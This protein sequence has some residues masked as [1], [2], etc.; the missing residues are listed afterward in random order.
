M[1]GRLFLDFDLFCVGG[2]CLGGGGPLRWY[3]LGFFWY[4]W[5]F[6]VP[7]PLAHF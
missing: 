1:Y 2:R 4:V 5:L 7:G 6:R 3:D